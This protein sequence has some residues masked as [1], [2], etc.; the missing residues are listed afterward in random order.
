MVQCKQNNPT[1][2][3]GSQCI[4]CGYD[5]R[6]LEIDSSCPECG[7]AIELSMRGDRLSL[8]DPAWIAKLA[9]GQ[10]L[11]VL[12]LK[13]FLLAICF[14]IISM[15]LVF[16]G[17]L[18]WGLSSNSASGP[19]VPSWLFNVIFTITGIGVF[20]G[21]IFT[22]IGCALVTTQ[23]PRDS[24]SE[25]SLSNRKVARIALFAMYASVVGY[26][27]LSSVFDLLFPSSN[28]SR[29]F[30][31]LLFLT[32]AIFITVSLV[33]TLRWLASLAVR[34]PDH[35]LRK[36]TFKSINFFRWAILVY[37]IMNVIS[38]KSL[39]IP[40]GGATIGALSG[41]A[42]FWMSI[43]CAS[44]IL[45]FVILFKSNQLYLTLREY[46]KTFR[47]CAAEAATTSSS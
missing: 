35:G 8:S 21:I 5:L 28:A 26:A 19:T 33:A 42:I 15:I 11:L 41:Q 14:G 47:K 29:I 12:G 31:Y 22:T 2:F 46:R 17:L 24:L 9:K 20:L 40:I 10:S 43:S 1:C 44:V 7:A 37:I 27:L 39:A 23:D 45:S 3:E 30:A 38:Q 18:V 36:R 34:I 13:I 25:T 4:T 16:V 32:I 6:G